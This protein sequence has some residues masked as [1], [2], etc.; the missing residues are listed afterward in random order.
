M[1]IGTT[2][3]IFIWIAL[4]LG[5]LVKI[6]IYT[7]IVSGIFHICSKVTKR[8][9]F[10]FRKVFPYVFVVFII[11]EAIFWLFHFLVAYLAAVTA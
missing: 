3:A 7:A 11:L 4:I 9:R 5:L 8:D 2:G 10:A 6:L 1:D